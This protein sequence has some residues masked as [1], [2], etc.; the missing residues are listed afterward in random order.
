LP[1][2]CLPACLP[3]APQ[4]VPWSTSSLHAVC[5]AAGVLVAMLQGGGGSGDSGCRAAAAGQAR[6]RGGA[7][8]GGL[9]QALTRLGGGMRSVTLTSVQSAAY[10]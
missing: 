5:A 1:G 6:Q 10:M 3:E 8:A 4:R 7:A 2:A 9:G